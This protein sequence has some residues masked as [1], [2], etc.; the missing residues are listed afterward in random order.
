MRCARLAFG[1]A[2]SSAAA[3]PG[4]V[5]VVPGS[6]PAAPARYPGVATLGVVT[7]SSGGHDLK[8]RV[9]ISLPARLPFLGHE[10]GHHVF[11]L[12]KDPKKAPFRDCLAYEGQIPHTHQEYDQH[13]TT[14]VMVAFIHNVL[15][16][17]GIPSDSPTPLRWREG[18]IV[19]DDITWLVGECASQVFRPAI[20]GAP[21]ESTIRQYAETAWYIW[22][23]RRFEPIRLSAVKNPEE[24][25]PSWESLITLLEMV[26]NAHFIH[27]LRFHADRMEQEGFANIISDCAADR[28]RTLVYS[29]TERDKYGVEVVVVAETRQSPSSP[30]SH[31]QTAASGSDPNSG[32]QSALSKLLLFSDPLVGSTFHRTYCEQA[33]APPQRASTPPTTTTRQNSRPKSPRPNSEKIL[34]CIVVAGTLPTPSP[35]NSPSSPRAPLSPINSRK[36]PI[37]HKRSRIGDK[38]VAVPKNPTTRRSTKSAAQH[39][40]R[41]SA[42]KDSV[43]W[44]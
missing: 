28:R 17:L 12:V 2:A 39:Y 24:Q 37:E 44:F 5:A 22:T 14:Q 4:L 19:Q 23:L 35:T 26:T 42:D 3:V 30:S 9:P 1:N 38:R 40:R 27:L 25:R 34:D 36:R 20:P 29:F 41:R 13:F 31:Q 10:P 15:G 6:P 16:A 43:K 7:K 8:V 18:R 32:G 11:R 33:L 21:D